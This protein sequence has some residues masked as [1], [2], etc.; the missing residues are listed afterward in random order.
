MK[1]FFAILIGMFLMLVIGTPTT[2]LRAEVGKSPPTDKAFIVTVEK[3]L[4]VQVVNLETIA[5]NVI[6][7]SSIDINSYTIQAIQKERKAFIWSYSRP[8]LYPGLNVQNDNIYNNLAQKVRANFIYK[9]PRDCLP[10]L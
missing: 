5:V 1:R 9:A 3:A 8:S 7:N 10:M 6:R 2:E 4:Q